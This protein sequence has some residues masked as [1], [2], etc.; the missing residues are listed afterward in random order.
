MKSPIVVICPIL[1]AALNEAADSLTFLPAP[2]FENRRPAKWCPCS[3]H[4]TEYIGGGEE[5][6]HPPCH[7][8]V[9]VEYKVVSCYCP[10][11][12]R[13]HA[14]THMALYGPGY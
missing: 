13:R 1:H 4:T 14:T 2:A 8:I 5:V 12:E 7:A 6:E 11:C 9:Q 3:G 10:E